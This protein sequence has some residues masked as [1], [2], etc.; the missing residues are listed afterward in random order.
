MRT[1]T[2]TLQN[3]INSNIRRP[4]L[5]LTAEDH[6]QHY[7]LYQSPNNADA[8]VDT[9]IAA[10][11]SII[12]AQVTRSGFTS[13]VQYQR[14]T[15]PTSLTQ[16]QTW[17]T[18]SGGSGNMF[19]DGGIA[20]SNNSGV[21]HIFAQRGTGGN[22][23]YNW[24]STNNGVTWTG[25]GT[26][27]SPPSSALTKAIGSAGNNDVF[28]IYDVVG[29][30]AIGASF[31][32]TSWS[33][34]HTWTLA[35]IIS[36]GGIAP[37]YGSPGPGGEYT[38]VYSDGQTLFQCT[39]NP[40]GSVWTA[41]NNVTPATT[42]ALARL[43]PRLSYDAATSLITL[44]CIEED[45][46]LLTGTVYQY[47]RLRQTADFTHWSNGF[48]LHGI[49]TLYGA[50]AFPLPVANTGSAGSRYYV[51][52]KGTVYSAPMFS[53]LNT[54]QFVDVSP[55]VLHYKRIE[56]PGKPATLDVTLDNANGILASYLCTGV[57]AGYSSAYAPIGP[58]TT[59]VLSEG[60]DTGNPPSTKEVVAVGK[61]RIKQIIMQRSPVQNQ[62]RIIAVDRSRDLDLQSR[63]QLSWTNQTVGW[64]IAEL[65]ARAGLFSLI[66]PAVSQISEVIA[67]YTLHAGSTYRQSLNEVCQTY[68][69]VYFMDQTD[70][71]QFK[72]LSL[73]DGSVWFYQPEI[74]LVS[75]GTVDD[76]ANHIIV[77]GKPPTGGQLG[78]LTTGEAYDDSDVSLVQVER[79]L[80]H[81]DQKL[82][83]TAQCTSKASFLLLQEARTQV[84][85]S[86][87]VPANP[88]LQMFDMIDVQDY[89][90]PVGSGLSSPGRIASVEIIFDAKKAQDDMIL[91]LEG[92]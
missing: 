34:I 44:C 39:Y 82:T 91:H 62:L 15:D 41:Q 27:L 17:T 4:Q 64:L 54:S 11:K 88:G 38:I 1:L 48:I 14:I 51:A 77:S 28:F 46:G 81:T 43:S 8:N 67:T 70:T 71:L 79:L 85:H 26:V 25:P 92:L 29:G 76:R 31:Y 61:Y 90:A 3:A 74:E 24:T 78:A 40:T 45:S 33:A 55:T 89:T 80:H 19:Q 59:L 83:T 49:S 22:Q 47:P 32:T 86:V 9:C 84:N 53:A 72:E 36:G 50:N 30:E 73:S 58:N 42:T 56:K 69:L 68:D 12:R 23:I 20:V 52:S 13:N 87:T 60:Y 2:T 21:L 5:T 57:N 66:I 18:L 16:W 35:P 65:C 6:V 7:T 75:F 63:Y 37:W 10:D